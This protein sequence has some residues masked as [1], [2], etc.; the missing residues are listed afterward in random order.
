MKTIIKNQYEILEKDG[1]ML[2]RTNLNGL[3]T[4]VLRNLGKLDQELDASILVELDKI[5]DVIATLD[6]KGV[7]EIYFEDCRHHKCINSISQQVDDF[8]LNEICDAILLILHDIQLYND[9]ILIDIL[10]NENYLQ[11]LHDY[12]EG[13]HTKDSFEKALSLE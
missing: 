4:G 11:V 7:K 2:F 3:L 10:F 9:T 13:K 12:Y 8:Y 6:Q 1:E 5:Y